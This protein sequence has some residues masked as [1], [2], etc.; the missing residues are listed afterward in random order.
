[1]SSSSTGRL[2][3]KRGKADARHLVGEIAGSP[4][5]FYKNT[6]HYSLFIINYSISVFYRKNGYDE[7]C[8]NYSLF[9]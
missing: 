9:G 3:P 2:P 6:I 7:W 5:R 1:M 8:F 4:N